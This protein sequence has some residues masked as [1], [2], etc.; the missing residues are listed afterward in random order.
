MTGNIPDCAPAASCIRRE[1]ARRLRPEELPRD[2]VHGR[3]DLKAALG[4]DADVGALGFPAGAIALGVPGDS[5]SERRHRLPWRPAEP[6]EWPKLQALRVEEYPDH[7]AR[8]LLRQVDVDLDV[9]GLGRAVAGLELHVAQDAVALEHQV[10]A[11]PVDLGAEHLDVPGALPPQATQKIPHEEVL[12]DI[13]APDIV[14]A[15]L[16]G[17]HPIEL[18]AKRLKRIRDLP[19]SWAEQRRVLGFA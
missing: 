16:A 18:T 12:E 11:G 15:I 6:E 13:L 2:H 8:R 17:R 19:V 3:Q 1:G 14:E 5:V 9:A 4:E 7:A 10:V